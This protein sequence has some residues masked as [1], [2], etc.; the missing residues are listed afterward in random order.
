ML[1][2]T[3][4]PSYGIYSGFESCEN[5]PVRPGSEEYLDSEKY[6][7]KQ[8]KLEGPLLPLVQRLNEIRRANRSLQRIDNVT[9][10]E[11]ANEQPD[12]LREAG[13]RRH[14]DRL[15]EPRPGRGLARACSRCRPLSTCRPRSSCRIC[16]P[17]RP[18]PGRSAATTSS[19]RPAAP[20]SCT[21]AEPDDSSRTFAAPIA[22]PRQRRARV[23]PERLAAAGHRLAPDR[24][25]V[26]GRPAVVQARGLLRDPH[27]RLRRRQRR[28]HRRPARARRRSSTTSSGS[29]STASGCCR[30]T[31]RRCAT[32][33]TTSP[34]SI[35]S[36]PTTARSRTSGR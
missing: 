17:T 10:L 34:T 4:S 21:S 15:R 30:C 3:L 9:F 24:A 22:D 32:A 7:L 13:R 27:P 12:R 1:A 25:V 5:V 35:R 8:R 26:R 11:T 14:G 28:R 31:P 29:A 20:T 16:S 23:Q 18:T 6:E 36:I 33:A 2:A 19:S